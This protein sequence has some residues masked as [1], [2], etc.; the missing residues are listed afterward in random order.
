MAYSHPSGIH[1]QLMNDYDYRIKWAT[2]ILRWPQYH[3]IEDII[4]AGNLYAQ[5]IM[6]QMKT[7]VTVAPLLE[8]VQEKRPYL[9]PSDGNYLLRH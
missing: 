1:D 5:H 8:P 2:F 7:S 4:K 9:A 3:K 6:D